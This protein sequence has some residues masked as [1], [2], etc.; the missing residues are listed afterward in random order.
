MGIALG[1]VFTG[2]IL[3]GVQKEVQK[4][5]NLSAALLT[6]KREITIIEVAPGVLSAL[7]VAILLL[8][9]S[10][11]MIFLGLIPGPVFAL[12]GIVERWRQK[13]SLWK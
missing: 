6:G 3:L 9:Y 4:H 12:Y 13:H 8:P 7:I 2:A 1:I 11:P 10:P 5:G